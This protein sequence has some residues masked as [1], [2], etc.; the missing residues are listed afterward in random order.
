MSPST[1]YSGTPLA[2]KLGIR[3]GSAVATVAAPDGFEALLKPLPEGAAVAA[4]PE[5]PATPAAP[6]ARAWDVVVAFAPDVEALARL[7][8]SVTF[9][10]AW[11]GGVWIA[12]P[13]GSSALASD[14]NRE[15][16]RDRL[17]ATG[18]VDNKVC[19]IDEDWSGL[20]FVHRVED[21]PG[22]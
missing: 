14:L 12:W 22:R 15:V 21:R 9:L 10:H 5:M 3:P 4:A 13:K 1:G 17:L 6:G 18:L 2:R 19:A 20:R 16:V 11:H 7:L 8:P